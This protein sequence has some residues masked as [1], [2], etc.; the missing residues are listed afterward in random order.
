L[1]LP[2]GWGLQGVNSDVAVSPSC[3]SAQTGCRAGP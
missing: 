1:A 2:G 3:T